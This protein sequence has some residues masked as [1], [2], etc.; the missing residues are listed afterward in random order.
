MRWDVRATTSPH[1]RWN[2]AAP[3]APTWQAE[4]FRARGHV[5]GQW[6]L[7]EEQGRLAQHPLAHGGKEHAHEAMVR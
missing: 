2:P 5:P 3:G 4:L 6:L 7:R 1:P